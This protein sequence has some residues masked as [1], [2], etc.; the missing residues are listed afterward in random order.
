MN[1][2][3]RLDV[4]NMD[5]SSILRTMRGA[6]R[7]GFQQIEI[8][9]KNPETTFIMK[10]D[11]ALVR[12][13][14]RDESVNHLLGSQ[15]KVIDQNTF[16]LTIAAG[17]KLLVYDVIKRTLKRLSEMSNELML[18][19]KGHLY[20][21]SIIE[22]NHDS[23]AKLVTYCM[24]QINTGKITPQETVQYHILGI[25][26]KL[27][28]FMKYISREYMRSQ[29]PMSAT[30]IKIFQ[31]LHDCIAA[32]E[33]MY[34]KFTTQNIFTLSLKRDDMK[35]HVVDIARSL[36]SRESYLIGK[37]AGILELITDL[38]E[39]RMALEHMDKQ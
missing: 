7:A 24:R 22:E 12:D 32:C 34:V 17:E 31:E 26:D 6:Y 2:K 10:S 29:R 35:R 9:S 33:V 38:M 8:F 37:A 14:V 16:L 30:G 21:V 5:R 23:I 13:I 1:K 19:F 4:S 25:I 28:D 11:K 36:D 18:L 20:A 3:I 15:L 39:S 27:A